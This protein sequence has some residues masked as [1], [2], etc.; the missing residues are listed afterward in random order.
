MLT[1]H[2]KIAYRNVASKYYNFVPEELDGVVKD[3]NQRL[4]AYGYE[5]EGIFFISLLSEPT[6]EVMTAKIFLPIV[7]SEFQVP[8]EEAID[9]NS[10]FSVDQLVMTRVK[11][12]VEKV[13]QEKYWEIV[14]YIEERGLQRKT[15]MFIEFKQDAAEQIYVEMSVGVLHS[16]ANSNAQ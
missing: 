15:P 7:E 5:T 11:E 1:E 6:A 9:F 4:L 14:H 12:E 10:Y 16:S 2:H 8:V 3:F 13:S